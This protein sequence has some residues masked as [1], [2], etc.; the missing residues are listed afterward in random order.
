MSVWAACYI[1]CLYPV[2]IF[3][4]LI[5]FFNI[6]LCPYFS[7]TDC[8]IQ[9]VRHKTGYAFKL[10]VF[11]Q[12]KWL[13]QF[14]NIVKCVSFYDIT[15]MYLCLHSCQHCQIQKTDL[16][17]KKKVGL[18][19]I[20]VLQFFAIFCHFIDINWRICYFS[21][22]VSCW[23]IGTRA[24]FCTAVLCACTQIRLAC[25]FC[26]GGNYPDALFRWK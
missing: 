13:I 3:H 25:L 22:L 24:T 7:L 5:K 11:K 14:Q 10:N 8:R 19:R 2:Y 9:D 6:L 4:I 21:S 12:L 15:G 18:S 16:D 20:D 26:Y 1:I 17:T 23:M